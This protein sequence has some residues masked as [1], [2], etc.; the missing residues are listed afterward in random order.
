MPVHLTKKGRAAGLVAFI[1]IG[2]ASCGGGGGSSQV[3]AQSY[4][5]GG[6]V[7]GLVGTG[8]QLQNGSGT[9]LGVSANGAFSF[10]TAV[11]SGTA[12]AISVAAQ[13]SSPSQTCVLSN[14]TGTVGTA[15]VT[16]ISVQCTTNTYKLGG[17]VSGLLGTGLVLQE[18]SESLTI[19]ANGAFTF[20][21][22]LASGAAYSI[23]VATQ[24][25]SPAQT[26]TVASGSGT[27]ESADITNITVTCAALIT[28]ANAASV[29]ALGNS[30]NET[31]MQFASFVGERLT[32]L[33]SHLAASATE[34][35]SDPYHEV[36][37]GQAAYIFSDNDASGSLTQG[38]TITITLT[39]CLSQ[40]MA[41]HVSGTVTLTLVQPPM[42]PA[43]GISFNAVAK[44]NPIS[45]TGLQITG[46]LNVQ[47]SAGEMVRSLLV[48]DSTAPLQLTYL[49][50]GWFPPDT[51]TFPTFTDTKSIDYEAAR[52]TVQI[53]SSFQS[54]SLGGTFSVDTTTPLSGRLGVYPDAGTEE[55]QGGVSR[56]NYSAQNVANNSSAVVSL[57]PDASGNFAPLNLGLFW[58]QGFNGFAWWEPRGYSI[59]ST[60]SRP[61]Y[62]TSNLGS[63]NMS[64]LFTDPQE[65][66]PI[67]NIL[68]TSFDIF[69]PLK[70]F[71]SGPV[72]SSNAS[73][74]FAPASYIVAQSPIPAILLVS[75]AVVS[76]SPQTQLQ[77][78]EQYTL[79][80]PNR[81]PTTW[82]TT[83]A[84]AT[85]DVQLT[86]PNS[87]QA[88]AVPSPGVAAPGQTVQ[89]LATG[90]FSANGTIT[91][92]TWRQA[93]GA[94]VSLAGVNSAAAS[95]I[96]PAGAQSGDSFHFNLTIDDA[97]GE[98][99]TVPVT[100]FV[101]TDLTQPFVYYRQQQGPAVG[102]TP[103]LAV[104][105][106]PLSGSIRTELGGSP[107]VFRFIFS[108]GSGSPSS[109][110]LQ[111]LPGGGSIAPG[112][113]TSA[114]TPG[115]QP[116]FLL[117]L[118]TCSGSGQPTWQ[119]TI[120]EAQAAPDGSAAKFSADFTQ[121]CPSG[122][123]TPFT[124]SVRV[125]S[126]VPLP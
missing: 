98:S 102:Q 31:V 10:P 80:T 103:E 39:G 45:L 100:V 83:S 3:T 35:C 52:Y 58:E 46:P 120:Y 106:S 48:D 85:V 84:G 14:G 109:D 112:T 51:V 44:L 116:F 2:L 53:D 122:I 108:G 117:S 60:N 67:N 92:Y 8:L 68:S 42:A 20:S 24:P 119:F 66:D 32:W 1:S 64:V 124:G 12:Y 34:T 125:N 63:W 107:D 50:N 30:L 115:G 79:Q 18:G 99:D 38:D 121:S 22:P 73:M 69:T 93:G 118:P 62:T 89:L 105:E 49:P 15:N 6:S 111:F 40:S 96:V 27:V 101:L 37:G 76:V 56:L 28:A 61:S 77:H 16:S 43:G 110:E 126:S 4:T 123:P 95:F 81:I 97:N 55:F 104:L 23:S 9:L 90:S 71:F 29:T 36:T 7:S 65:A 94:T 57:D 13:P 74:V 25:T 21:T 11:A 70:V 114:S 91:G 72:D 19:S 33:S 54:Q 113:Y 17:T 75:G 88:N 26:C 86:T 5:I 78:G 82:S 41:D 87:L 47:Y 59:V